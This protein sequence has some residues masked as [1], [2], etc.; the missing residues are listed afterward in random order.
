M[1]AGEA[2][3]MT[4]VLVISVVT[5]LLILAALAFWLWMLVDCAMN[6]SD[7]GNIR[8]IWVLIIIFVHFIGA[9]LYFFFQRRKRLGQAG[10]AGAAASP[11]SNPA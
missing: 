6:E 7:E 3:V 11:P 5:G 10:G 8:L 1:G 4:T 2:V 9:I